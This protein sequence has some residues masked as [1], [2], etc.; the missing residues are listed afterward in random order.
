M[1][2]AEMLPWDGQCPH[3]EGVW[4]REGD[5][6]FRHQGYNPYKKSCSWTEI[7]WKRYGLPKSEEVPNPETGEYEKPRDGDWYEDPGTGKVFEYLWDQY[8]MKWVWWECVGIED[9][10]PLPGRQVP[11]PKD[12]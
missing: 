4:Y 3:A 10:G 11:P 5:R 7:N 8:N 9:Y 2:A 1:N 12:R 6:V